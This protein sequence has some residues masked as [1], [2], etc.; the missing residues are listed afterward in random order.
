MLRF[1]AFWGTFLLW[2][3]AVPLRT[4][5]VPAYSIH[6]EQD[7][8]F[9]RWNFTS[10]AQWDS[11]WHWHP[12]ERRA[13]QRMQGSSP[14]MAVMGW[15]PYWMGTRYTHYQYDLL[16]TIAY[17]SY[18]VDPE[19]GSY[20]TVR[21]W[22]T[23]NLVPLAH[24]YGTKVVL[25]V[26]NFGSDNNRKL[27]TNPQAK[28][29]LIDSLIALV[30]RR[31]ADGVNIDFE[32]ISYPWLRDSL[33]LFL[34]QLAERFHQEIPGSEV[35]IA[36]PA[37][38]WYHV[39]DVAAYNAFLDYCVLMG[40]EYHW[41]GSAYA[42]P[43]APL[44]AG[45]IWNQWCVDWSVSYYLAQGLLP[46]K[47]WLGVP[48]YGREWPVTD[49]TLP[50]PTTGAGKAYT[51]EAVVEKRLQGA[52]WHWDGH[53]QTPYY[54][55]PGLQQGWYD[56]T[57]SLLLKYRYARQF[58][59]GG[60]GIWA[61]GYDGDRPELWKALRSTIVGIPSSEKVPEQRWQYRQMPA[62]LV[63]L[64]SA[65]VQFPVEITV[66][67]MMGK[68]VLYRHLLEPQSA[69]ML[70]LPELPAQLYAVRIAEPQH[71]TTL[72]LPLAP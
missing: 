71:L 23:T 12:E 28:Q 48:Y 51:Y 66:Y 3:T 64:P 6:A 35:S 30:R 2:V 38:D 16:H 70:S 39:F 61:L 46:H 20:R 60:I 11:L 36:L 18:A 45:S 44:T 34:Q 40:Y 21:Q 56:D 65:S 43:V 27:L 52:H 7:H 22:E 13:W 54:N 5:W 42:G 50:S 25:C 29:A 58:Q 10:E 4:Q 33:T 67:T 41:T 47:L 17:F 19:T 49:T 15:H 37:V 53:S 62:G 69:I 26:T 32:L 59:L 8:F 14:S 55:R 57:T 68:Q 63:L 72:V 9:Q 1:A 31:N 24:Q